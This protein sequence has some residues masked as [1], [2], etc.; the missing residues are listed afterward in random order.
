MPSGNNTYLFIQKRKI[1]KNEV[2]VSCDFKLKNSPVFK[3]FEI[4][5][6]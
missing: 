5:F 4:V 6:I 3:L 2:Q 1:L